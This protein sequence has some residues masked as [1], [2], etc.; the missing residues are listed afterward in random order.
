MSALMAAPV[1]ARMEHDERC[2]QIW[3]LSHQGL[4]IKQIAY[5]LGCEAPGH[6]LALARS[7]GIVV[8]GRKAS[9]GWPTKDSPGWCGETLDTRRQKFWERQRQG[10]KEA[11]SVSHSVFP[12]NNTDLIPGNDTS[13]FDGADLREQ[14]LRGPID[15][16]ELSTR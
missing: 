15:T 13:R 7:E 2:R 5:D 8:N 11:L 10:A 6:V 16:Q 3:R 4:T 1:W 14:V 12:V 9:P